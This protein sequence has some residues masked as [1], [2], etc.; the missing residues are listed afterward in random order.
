MQLNDA[1]HVTFTQFAI[2]HDPKGN[3]HED[4]QNPADAKYPIHRSPHRDTVAPFRRQKLPTACIK[5]STF[6]SRPLTVKMYRDSN[7]D[8]ISCTS[9]LT[10]NSVCPLRISRLTCP[11]M[12]APASM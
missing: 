10:L 5:R 6:S 11:R 8:L 3:K 7:K 1:V 2:S 12:S 4:K 9:I